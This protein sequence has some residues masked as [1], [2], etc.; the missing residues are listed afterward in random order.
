[1]G[2]RGEGDVVD[3][4]VVGNELFDALPLVDIPNGAGGVNR[5]RANNLDL[6]GIPVKR[7][8]GRAQLLRFLKLE[9]KGLHSLAPI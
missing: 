8:E 2:V 6:G 4:L 9:G 3:L 1:M 5:G 7:C